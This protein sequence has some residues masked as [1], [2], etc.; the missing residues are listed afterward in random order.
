MGPPS[1][2]ESGI[3]AKWVPGS[4]KIFTFIVIG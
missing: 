3:H 2:R 1:L 4:L